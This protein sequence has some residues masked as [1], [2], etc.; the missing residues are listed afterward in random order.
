[1][2]PP[3]AGAAAAVLFDVEDTLVPWQTVAH[4]Q[5]AWRPRGP[6]LAE[7]HVLAAL[8]RSVHAWD[9]RRWQGLVGEAPLAD[10]AAYREHLSATLSAIAGHPLPP[11]E[12]EAV[13]SRFLRPAGEIETFA[14]TAPCLERLR[15]A[16]VKIG[17]VS[18]LSAEDA[19]FTLKRAGLG[20]LAVV[21]TASSPAPT[22]PD[23][24]AFR[25]AARAL[26]VRPREALFVGDLFWSDVRAAAR[27]GFTSIFID[28]RDWSPRVL[29][30]RIHTLAEVPGL[31]LAPPTPQE[32]GDSATAGPGPEPPAP[33]DTG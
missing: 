23:P 11:A 31:A 8:H 2:A 21:L 20:G 7:R 4:W 28:R 30:R 13:V 9:R 29:A 5:W 14:D 19:Q 24:V 27:V 15:S 32:F 16:G 25:A 10:L 17:V 1:M 22:L 6:V 18:T 3:P 26:G 33:P 12:T